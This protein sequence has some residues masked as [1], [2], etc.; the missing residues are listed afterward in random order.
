MKLYF[1]VTGHGHP[2]VILHGL[3]GS[4]D[5]WFSLS[6]IFGEKYKVFA[7]DLRNHGRSPHSDL[8]DYRVMAEDIN[9]LLTHEGIQSAFL[10]GHSL[11]G[12]TAMQFS[13]MY[14]ESVDKL[15]VVDIAPRAYP[16][17]HDQIFE[18][19]FAMD[20]SKYKTRPE[21]D[22]AM[23]QYIADYAV[24]QLLLKNAYRDDAGGFRWRLDVSAL[25]KNYDKVNEAIDGTRRFTKPALFVKGAKSTYLLEEDKPQIRSMFTSSQFVTVENAGHWVHA[26]APQKF[27]EVVMEFLSA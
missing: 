24:R 14:P 11:G 4:S 18:A 8:F 26:E 2:L 17:K 19:L 23:S 9:N 10:L 20:L 25:H 6:R 1:H 22:A 27:V 3:F 13:L 5:N 12:K 7:V 15:I 16:P 21:L